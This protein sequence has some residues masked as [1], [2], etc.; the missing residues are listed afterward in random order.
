[1]AMVDMFWEGGLRLGKPERKPIS[2]EIPTDQIANIPFTGSEMTLRDEVS[3]FNLLI[4]AREN[5]EYQKKK[6]EEI[7]K[8]MLG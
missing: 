8:F 1:M 2:R 5:D 3:T 4:R 7:K 6:G